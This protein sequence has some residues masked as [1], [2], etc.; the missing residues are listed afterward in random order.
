M[1]HVNQSSHLNHNLSCNYK[2]YSY[3]MISTNHLTSKSMIQEVKGS[4]PLNLFFRS[5]NKRINT[6]MLKEKKYWKLG[7]GSKLTTKIH[8]DLHL[9]LLQDKNRKPC[10]TGLKYSSGM[11]NPKQTKKLKNEL[12]FWLWSQ[13]GIRILPGMEGV[14]LKPASVSNGR[15]VILHNLS[16]HWQIQK[17]KRLK[18]ITIV[19]NN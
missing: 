13:M 14:L 12:S 15:Q 2:T 5:L 1:Y 17:V 19:H 16:I 10:K 8:N 3:W 4:N 7:I 9:D 11:K 18:E 6:L